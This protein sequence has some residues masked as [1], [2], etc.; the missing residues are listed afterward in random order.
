MG[1]PGRKD[2]VREQPRGRRPERHPAPGNPP[3]G[4]KRAHPSGIERRGT[5]G[6]EAGTR[7]RGR[8]G[9]FAG[10]RRV[11]GSCARALVENNGRKLRGRLCPVRGHAQG[12]TGRGLVPKEPTERGQRKPSPACDRVHPYRRGFPDDSGRDVR[13]GF[14]VAAGTPVRRRYGHVTAGFGADLESVRDPA[15]GPCRAAPGGIL[16]EDV[17]RN[18]LRIGFCGAVP[19]GTREHRPRADL[20]ASGGLGG[21]D[22]VGNPSRDALRRSAREG[23]PPAGRAV[24][25]RDRGPRKEKRGPPVSLDRLGPEDFEDALP[26]SPGDLHFGSNEQQGRKPFGG[27]HRRGLLPGR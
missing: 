8:P 3:E 11:Q 4:S 15:S 5:G 19:A 10:G 6:P 20:V 12:R 25:G 2:N 17:H 1:K 9:I 7:P 21:L 27:F 22:A 14:R 13:R 16:P 24:F 26:S 18:R 23:I